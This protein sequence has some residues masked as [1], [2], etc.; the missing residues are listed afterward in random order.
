MKKIAI[1]GGPCSGKTATALLLGVELKMIG[2]EVHFV[3]EYATNYIIRNGSPKN[4]FEQ[5]AIFHG[6]KDEEGYIEKNSDGDF[7]ICDSASF[8]PCVYARH[9]KPLAHANREDI[10]KYN[11]VLKTLDKWAR[12]QTLASYAHIFF[13]PMEIIFKENSVRWQKN[14]DEAKKISEEIE[15]YLKIEGRQYHTISGSPEERVEKALKIIQEGPK[16]FPLIE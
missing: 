4:I 15:S 9:Y 13:L 16:I 14:F 11:Y 10:Q 12:E 1:V 6:Q 2:Y 5:L 7:L 3:L 8:L